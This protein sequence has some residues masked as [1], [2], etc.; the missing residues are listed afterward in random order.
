MQL[1]G[2]ERLSSWQRLGLV[3]FFT[4]LVAFAG[5]VE[6]RSAFLSKRMGDLD[7]FLR[8][9][10]ALRAGVDIYSVTDLDAPIPLPNQGDHYNYPPFLAVLLMPLADPP[11][12][13]DH[14]GFVP[15]GVSVVI[16]YFFNLALMAL[17]VHCLASAVAETAI[18]TPVPWSRRWWGLRILPVLV[19]LVP[20]G[21]SLMRGQSNMLVLVSLCASL[22]ATIRGQ[23]FRGGFWLA[24]AISVKIFPAFLG[25]YFLWRR[26]L[27]AIVGCAAGLF[28]TLVA[29]PLVVLEPAQTVACY[30]RLAEA[31]ILPGFGL[32]TDESRAHELTNVASVSDNQ[33]L[34]SVTHKT[35]HPVW[36]IRPVQASPAVRWGTMAAGLLLTVVPL[37]AFGWRGRQDPIALILLF[38][39]LTANML[40]LSPVCHLHYSTFILPL[41][42][43]LLAASWQARPPRKQAFGLA[44]L[45]VVVAI[46]LVLPQLPALR[47]A[48]ELGLAAYLTLALWL[49][50]IVVIRQ[51]R[52]TPAN[53]T[54]N[55]SAERGPAVPIAWR[56]G[57]D[58]RAAS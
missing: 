26:D 21:H 43:G 5:L 15:Y 35:L 46:G 3:G 29:V 9:A 13:V 55:P 16:W 51:R 36:Q 1:R 19:L 37:A 32:G 48:R 57:S 30:E 44:A 33:S 39:C 54:E 18:E 4:L 45:F 40:F 53:A 22:A 23:R 25:L 14:A 41:V 52:M 8:A 28:V 47:L 20:L 11:P 24:G 56:S 58:F 6:F 7:I 34:L 42:M 10:W 38:G 49:V 27:R 31:V 17:A 12:E 2:G 50:A